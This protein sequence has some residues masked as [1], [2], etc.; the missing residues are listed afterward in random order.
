[1]IIDK[2]KLVTY[3]GLFFMGAVVWYYFIKLLFYMLG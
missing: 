2:L 1:M 3:V